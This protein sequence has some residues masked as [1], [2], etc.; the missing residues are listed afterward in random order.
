MCESLQH[1]TSCARKVHSVTYVAAK[2][3]SHIWK[4]FTVFTCFW[5]I[6][7][8]EYLIGRGQIG[9][10]GILLS[11]KL[12][13]SVCLGSVKFYVCTGTSTI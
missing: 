11:K 1:E 5:L 3:I 6:G 4:V 9:F 13:I 8:I 12:S 7:S 2:H 10:H